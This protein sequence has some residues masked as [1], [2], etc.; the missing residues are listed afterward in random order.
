M[1]LARLAFWGPCLA[2]FLMA[3]PSSPAQEVGS[4]DLTQSSEVP[5]AEKKTDSSTSGAKEEKEK[6]PVGCPQILPGV[7][8][9]GF[10]E[11]EDYQQRPILVELVKI[12]KDNPTDGREIE[13]EIRLQ[14]SGTQSIKIPW[15]TE[16]GVIE[17]GQGPFDYEWEGGYFQVLFRAGNPNGVLLISSDK[18][19]YGSNFVVG[20]MLTL[21]PGQWVTAKVN[22]KLVA[23][24]FPK[25]GA[26]AGRKAELFVQ[27]KQ[28]KR[29]IRVSDCKRGNFY[30]RFERFYDEEDRG[31]IIQV[32]GKTPSSSEKDTKRPTVPQMNR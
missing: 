4:I 11:P 3:V 12:S 8:G 13:A 22:F 27:W 16:P 7:I 25:E 5:A 15:S 29:S 31:I 1:R 10:V 24:Y 6:V 18:E 20:S 2:V 19:L 17:M 26:F 23:Q 30:D 9:D 14:N 28:V 32:A 21:E